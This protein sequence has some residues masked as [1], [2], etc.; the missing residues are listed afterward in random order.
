MSLRH[1]VFPFAIFD[2][3]SHTVAVYHI[4]SHFS[5][6][7]YDITR[8]TIVVYHIINQF[9]FAVLTSKVIQSLYKISNISFL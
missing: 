9:P 3:Q 1:P 5:F 4:K 8:H 7:V 2:I 6:A